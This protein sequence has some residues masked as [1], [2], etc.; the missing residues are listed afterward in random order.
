ME[1]HP[2][3]GLCGRP[4]AYTYSK[5]AA[6][7]LLLQHRQVQLR[8]RQQQ[9]QQQQQQQH[10]VQPLL[11]LVVVRPSIVAATWKDPFPGWV[12][13]FNGATGGWN[14]IGHTL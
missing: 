2:E 10:Q 7:Q 4:N 14:G 11:P 6:E 5:A 12:E 1:S 3:E 13:N 8:R 9:Q